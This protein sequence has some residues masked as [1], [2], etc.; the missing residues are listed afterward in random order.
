MQGIVD[1]GG[2]V[3][4]DFVLGGCL[5]KLVAQKNGLQALLRYSEKC[6]QDPRCLL[7]SLVTPVAPFRW[8]LSFSPRMITGLLPGPHTPPCCA[9]TGDSAREVSQ[10]G[11]QAD[12]RYGSVFS[13]VRRGRQWRVRDRGAPMYDWG[14]RQ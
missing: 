13:E 2:V 5:R 10:D 12:R 4:R 7:Y 1:T 3:L 14:P 6:E 11:H 8:F 9:V